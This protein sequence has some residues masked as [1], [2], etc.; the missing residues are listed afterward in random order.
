MVPVG[1]AEAAPTTRSLGGGA[2]SWFGDP[3]AVH[4]QGTYNRTYI[5]WIDRDGDIKVASYDHSTRVRTT[6]VLAWR[7]G[8]D[9]HNNPSLHVLPDGRLMVFYS[10]AS[11]KKMSYRVTS[12]PE[13][14]TSWGRERTLATNTSGP[15]GYT[16]PN[17]VQLR[18]EGNRLW[19]FWRGGN[20]QPTF[21]TSTNGANTWATA[22]TLVRYSGERPYIKFASNDRNTIHFAFTQGH[23]ANVNSNIYYAFYKRGYFYRAG[24]TRIKRVSQ[25]PLSP[26]EASRVDTTRTNAW[27]HDI[28][29]DPRGRPVIVYATIVSARQHYYWYARWIGRRWQRVRITPAGASIAGGREMW[30]SGG[31]TLDHE[32]TSVVYLSREVNGIHEVETWRTPNGGGSWRR[33]AVTSGSSTENVR[34]ISPRGLRSFDDDMSVVWMGGNYKHY[35]AYQTDITTRLLNGANL[36]PTAAATVSPRS[37]RAPLSARF[38]GG[39]SKDSD[40]AIVGWSW[41]FGDGPRVEHVPR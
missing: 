7:L 32:N 35:V 30:Y 28:A 4:H 5:G 31:I 40:G 9:D 36:P 27:I 26:S 22:R 34:P 18:A 3:R 12:R 24:G 23:P 8:I 6:A 11:R 2:W 25:L 29:I 10:R 39:Q 1:A 41:N 21:S 17:P 16:Y 19:L 33:Q 37:G 15:R 14:I 38:R 13:D 20:W